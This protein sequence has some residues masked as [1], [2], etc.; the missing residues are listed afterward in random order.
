[1][2]RVGAVSLL[3]LLSAPILIQAQQPH[4][5]VGTL[6]VRAAPG[7]YQVVSVELPVAGRDSIVAWQARAVGGIQLLGAPSGRLPRVKRSLLLTLVIPAGHPPGRVRALEIGFGAGDASFAHR[8]VDVS[9]TAT[10]SID[11]AAGVSTVGSRPGEIVRVRFTIWNRGNAAD[12]LRFR[13]RLPPGWREE[14][15][16]AEAVV[17]PGE[18]REL[19]VRARVAGA[20][21]AGSFTVRLEA[22]ASGG[23]S[24]ASDASVRVIGV[25]AR[26]HQ[27]APVLSLGAAFGR[28]PGSQTAAAY[29]AHVEGRIVGNIRVDAGTPIGPQPDRAERALAS[30]GYWRM[31]A[32]LS[33]STETWRANFGPTYIRFSDVAGA[34]LVGRGV[35]IQ[36]ADT[37]WRI[38]TFAAHPYGGR[39]S[40]GTLGA[41]AVERRFGAFGLGVEGAHLEEAG[42]RRR[43]LDA[44]GAVVRLH[45]R[46]SSVVSAELVERRFADARALG[47]RVAYGWRAREGALNAYA[48]RA[49]GGAAAFARA[50]TEFGAAGFRPISRRLTLGGSALVTHDST[51][52]WRSLGSR[53][54]T[55]APT[56]RLTP[57]VVLLLEGTT[58]GYDASG[59]AGSTEQ[60]ETRLAT[61]FDAQRGPA[62]L[63]A[64]VAERWV[65]RA[66]TTST[67]TRSASA[68]LRH[69]YRGT[70]GTRGP[71][72]DAQL[73]TILQ[74]GR[75]ISGFSAQYSSYGLRLDRITLLP[76]RNVLLGSATAAVNQLASRS[77]TVVLRGAVRAQ[78]SHSTRMT[79]AAERDPYSVL[80]SSGG[81]LFAAMLQ[82][83][84]GLPRVSF[85]PGGTI[86]HDANNNAHRDRGEPGVAGV[87]VR[88]LSAT[89]VTDSRGRYRFD[90][91]VRGPLRIDAASIPGELVTPP[92]L[93]RDSLRRDIGLIT[94]ASVEVDV[95]VEG[96]AASRVDSLALQSV[97]VSARDAR[98]QQWTAR[99]I[100]AG[101][102]A[103]ESLPVGRYRIELDLSGSAEPLLPVDSLPAFDVV[104]GIPTAPVRVRLRTRNAKIRAFPSE[105][106]APPGTPP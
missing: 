18:R 29:S 21:G 10:S 47:G 12:T 91:R 80:A 44:A 20:S 51:A 86:F 53:T 52:S 27:G 42:N 17:A 26:G 16:L 8:S 56:M 97:V 32:R 87:I 33:L 48:Y 82:H 43:Q 5:T 83:D 38:L 4:D 3:A 35:S 11:L 31:P 25:E 66:T 79:V 70:L 63:T 9:V 59:D 57:G 54:F 34:D 93:R 75:T 85:G 55:L 40:A 77:G 60:R 100:R 62:H 22:A 64:T 76:G 73:Y 1:M 14:G 101:R 2:R 23:A 88:D 30:A 92:S 72:G 95:A 81:W 96:F 106:A 65:R 61:G 99:G 89:T 104:D 98:G 67:G 45:L 39:G 24:A 74:R 69:E 68:A 71:F 36:V 13:T 105:P 46:S 19:V 41:F 50:S 90:R 78:L 28:G 37:A 94:V 103:L 84:I 49:P 15:R 58:S 7:S 102:W 6:V